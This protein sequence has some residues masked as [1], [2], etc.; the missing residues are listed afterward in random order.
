MPDIIPAGR[1]MKNLQLLVVDRASLEQDKPRLCGVG[2]QGDIFVR[3][4]GLAE[5]YLSDDELN[6]KK[7]IPNFFLE[8][9]NVWQKNPPQEKAWRKFWNDPRDRLYR[10]I[11]NHGLMSYPH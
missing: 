2:E 11:S 4:G 5:G 3:A 7:F 1:G 9:P 10:Y 6:R 8:N